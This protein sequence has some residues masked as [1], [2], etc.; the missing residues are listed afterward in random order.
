MFFFALSFLPS[1]GELST[2]LGVRFIRPLQGALLGDDMGLGKTLQLLS[3]MAKVL[4]ENPKADPFLVVA[5]VSL[6]ENWVEE[7]GKFFESG[8]FRALTLYGEALAAKRVPKTSLDAELE[9][10]V[11]LDSSRAI[12]LATPIL[13]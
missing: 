8:T 10:R 11:L 3:F 1:I 7:M 5:P 4:E 9:G 12:G 2:Y 13:Y 6:L